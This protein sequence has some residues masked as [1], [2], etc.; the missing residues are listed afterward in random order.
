MILLG[1]K[2][3]NCTVQV[4]TDDLS[5]EEQELVHMSIKLFKC[6]KARKDT[7]FVSG[8]IVF[9][10]SL[11]IMGFGM[12][13]FLRTN[14]ESMMS[15]NAIL[16]GIILVNL[17]LG[18]IVGLVTTMTSNVNTRDD[19]KDLVNCLSLSPCV[20]SFVSECVANDAYLS[21][22]LKQEMSQLAPASNA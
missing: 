4:R 21:K 13:D 3:E 22:I 14:L 11:M 6:F 18:C 7:G 19:V 8:C 16:V 12:P 20:Y 2:V 1:I 15:S 5:F 17:V 9:L 10:I